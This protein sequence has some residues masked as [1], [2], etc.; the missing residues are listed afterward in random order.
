MGTLL[1]RRRYMGDNQYDEF[2]Y[3]KD[4]KIFHLDGID[5]GATDGTWVDL[6]GGKVFTSTSSTIEPV[7]NGFHFSR[8]NDTFVGMINANSIVGNANWTM[9]CACVADNAQRY[10]SIFTSSYRGYGM[11][12]DGSYRFVNGN[13]AWTTSNIKNGPVV[14][15]LGEN[16]G[17]EN[18]TQLTT[19]WGGIGQMSTSGFNVGTCQN[20]NHNFYG[21]IHSI[22]IYNR[23]L[24][25]DEIIHNQQIDNERFNLGLTI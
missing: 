23:V 14:L 10:A 6:I 8:K 21:I 19:K 25:F 2:G 15:A 5:K 18:G 16:I 11:A 3:I 12:L 20:R 13:Y 4:G 17:V 22:R 9:E 24:T 1:N 7:S